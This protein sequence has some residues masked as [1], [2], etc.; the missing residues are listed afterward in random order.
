MTGPTAEPAAADRVVVDASVAV[1]WVL[2]EADSGRARAL[3]DEW[4]RRETRLLALGLLA[5][6]LVSVMAQRVRRGEL[7]P[8]E[9]VAVVRAVLLLCPPA[10]S[11]ELSIRALELVAEPGGGGTYDLH[12]VALAEQERC[13][14][15]TAD[16]R[17]WAK[18]GPRLGQDRWIGEVASV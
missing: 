4:A 1:T 15:W 8:A 6:E 11:P 14:L 12:Y 9:G 13:E 16:G 3:L 18:V 5:S 7:R 2:D 10:P 17:F